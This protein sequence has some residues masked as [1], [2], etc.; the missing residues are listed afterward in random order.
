VLISRRLRC[1]DDGSEKAELSFLLDGTWHR[2][3]APWSNIMQAR[4]IPQYADRGLRVHSENARKVVS[5][6]ADLLAVNQDLIPL[7][8]STAHLGWVGGW[9]GMGAKQFIP[10]VAGD[11]VLDV[12]P[13][14]Q[15]TVE[16]YQPHGQF[17]A[18][19]DGMAEFR[20]YPFTRFVLAAGFASCMLTPL[21]HRVFGLHLWG[22]SQHGKTAALKAALS[23]W[24][25]PERLLVTFNATKVGL[26]RVA[27]LYSDLPLGI[28]ERQAADKQQFIEALVYML[29]EGK[30]KIR[31]AKGGGLQHTRHWRLIALSTGEEPL[32]AESSQTGV[33]TRIMEL[34]VEPL[35]DTRLGRRL[36]ALVNEHHGHAG[37][38][39]VERL[40]E[41]IETGSLAE[42]FSAFC[43]LLE[44]NHAEQLA[45]HLTAM[46]V[47]C[48]A[49]YYA[50]QWVWNIPEPQA[51]DEALKLAEAVVVE[52]ETAREADYGSRAYE[53]LLSWLAQHHAKFVG[54]RS[55]EKYGEI[56]RV[57][58][59]AYIFPSVLEPAMRAAGFVPIRVYRDL[60]AR[61]VLITD[62]DKKRYKKTTWI[63]GQ[64]V[65]VICVAVGV[66][67]DA[68]GNEKW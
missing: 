18:W 14:S 65:K 67:V 2:L 3:T 9:H 31:G 16:A 38:L 21:R 57:A 66:G 34:G 37:P 47:V 7:V 52:P 64:P 22:P 19:R 58:A 68:R 40:M 46:A 6:L 55:P 23:V 20:A 5:Y 61:G 53:W 39:F 26:E 42:D 27:A 33:K 45:S 59:C 48:L 50:S 11:I 17:E 60:K 54:D 12:D 30:G 1:V 10:G 49:D 25:D 43:E 28:D 32:S 4:S 63:D 35:P 62:K 36:H 13:E 24:G 15:A 51:Y 56:D 41:E 44:K 29:G 8:R